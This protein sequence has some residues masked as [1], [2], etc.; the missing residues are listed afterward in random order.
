MLNIHCKLGSTLRITGCQLVPSCHHQCPCDE[1]QTQ[2]VTRDRS[3]KPSAI[4]RDSKDLQH[5]EDYR[6][7]TCSQSQDQLRSRTDCF[8]KTLSSLLEPVVDDQRHHHHHYPDS[9]TASAHCDV[10]DK[11]WFYAD[12]DI[13]GQLNDVLWTDCCVRALEHLS[14]HHHHHQQQQQQQQLIVLSQSPSMFPIAALRLGLVSNICFLD[15][16]PVYQPLIGRLISANGL[17]EDHVTYG[18]QW[19]RDVTSV[20]FA[21]IVPTEG[22]LHQNVFES[23]VEAWYV[24][25]SVCLFV[26]LNGGSMLK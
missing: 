17:S 11:V 16:D 4:S 19:Q 1:P 22:C 26:S 20:L 6:S 5:D 2:R 10:I 25:L 7:L 13:I 8:H 9:A 3:P 21:D 12:R 14:H 15:L 23:L 24:C 18:R